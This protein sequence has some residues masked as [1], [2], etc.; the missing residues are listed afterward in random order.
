MVSNIKRKFVKYPVMI[1]RGEEWD[2]NKVKY[3]DQFGVN[4]GG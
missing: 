3:F 2:T 4:C 1:F